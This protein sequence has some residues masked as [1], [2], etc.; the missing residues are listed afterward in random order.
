MGAA[1]VALVSCTGRSD[2]KPI[3]EKLYAEAESAYHHGDLSSAQS[4][5]EADYRNFRSSN[6]EWAG[7]FRVLQVQVMLLRGLYEPAL[8]E[9]NNSPAGVFATCE[10]AARKHMLEASAYLR[11]GRH[12]ESAASMREAERQCASPG[13]ILAADLATRRGVLQSD[14]PLAEA[15]YRTALTIARE[16]HDT[17]REAGALVNLSN[18]SQGQEHYDESIDWASASLRISKK[19]SYRLYEEMTEGN[20]AFDYYKLGD[21]D[22]AAA[23]YTEAEASALICGAPRD[24]SLWRENLG[25]IHEQIGEFQAAENDYR[26]A[27]AMARQQ[28]DRNQTNNALLELAFVFIRTGNWDQA[29]KSSRDGLELAREDENRPLELRAMLA[30]GLIAL[31]RGDQKAAEKLLSEVARD[32]G[33]DRQSFRWEAQT[34]LANLYAGERR[35]DAAKAEYEEALETVRQARCSIHKEDYR[36]SFFTSATRVYSSYIDFL[37]QQGKASVALETADESRAL[38]LAEGLG[39]DG[40]KCL[41][42]ETGFNPQRVARVAKATILFYWLGPEHSYLWAVDANRLK[43][44]PLP[45]AS[46]IDPTLQAYRKTLVGSRDVLETGDTNGSALYQ[47]LVA[48]AEE[49]FHADP[50]EAAQRVIVIADGALS[51]LNLETLISPKPRPH[52]WIE[53][54]CVENAS[55]LRL[56]AARPGKHSQTGGRLLL[57]GDPVPPKGSD[58]EALPNAAK[59][60]LSVQKSFP[61]ASAQVYGER[62]STPAAYLDGHPEQFAFIHFVAHGV[63]SLTDPLDSAVVLSPTVTPANDGG[64][65]LYAREVMAHPLRAELVTISTCKGAG[66]RSYTGEGLVGLSWA[67]LHTGAHHVIGALWD[68]SDESTPQLMAGMYAE[69]VNGT[70]PDAALRTAKLTLLH[71][72]APF[73]KPYYWAPFQ[74]YTGS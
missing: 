65:K 7:K 30:Q 28:E 17:Y 23:L 3:P 72:A 51:G 11:L 36:L 61:G 19:M 40:Q 39:I 67:F 1:A 20:L 13:P 5:A 52:Y 27:L 64:Y 48:P 44:Y 66:V 73:H 2:P 42:T 46:Q 47:T 21:F 26:Q 60:M 69:L 62:N 45:P 18:A 4:E 24:R 16:Q 59:E 38:T 32:P 37:V 9:L 58:F 34:A 12:S 50:Q 68:V 22:Q 10:L 55:S 49:F 33:H 15:E 63:A 56:L 70:P 35:S 54:V 14:L 57:I 29:E 8:A 6:P 53:D 25:L 71:S 43:L 31:H 74:L 41:S